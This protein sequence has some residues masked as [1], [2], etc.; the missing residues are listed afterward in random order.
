MGSKCST[1]GKKEKS[2]HN[3]DRKTWSEETT[4]EI[5]G[6]VGIGGRIILKWS[7]GK[8]ESEVKALLR[9][10]QWNFGEF[11]DQLSNWQLFKIHTVP[12]SRVGTRVKIGALF[13][14]LTAPMWVLAVVKLARLVKDILGEM[15][16]PLAHFS[17]GLVISPVD[18][19]VTAVP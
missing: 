1:N 4:W 7:L 9:S 3:F 2:I 17:V 5:V 18:C 10:R 14:T 12:W 11:L 6:L 8:W 15:L 19:G 13:Y 16:H